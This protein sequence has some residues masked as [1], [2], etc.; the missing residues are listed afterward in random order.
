MTYRPPSTDHPDQIKYQMTIKRLEAGYVACAAVVIQPKIAVRGAP[1]TTM[2]KRGRPRA[3]KGFS[4][5][6]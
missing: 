6:A 2:A 3:P 5:F 1:D 4:I